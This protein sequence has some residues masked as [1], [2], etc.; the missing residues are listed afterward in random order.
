MAVNEA[1]ID[2]GGDGVQM[3]EARL[4]IAERYRVQATLADG[5]T[6]PV[7]VP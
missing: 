2:V 3:D 1:D 6:V 5:R 4:L 7:R